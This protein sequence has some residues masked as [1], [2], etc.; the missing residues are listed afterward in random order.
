MELDPL[1]CNV[2][3]ARYEQFAAKKAARVRLAARNNFLLARLF[4]TAIIITTSAA[5]PGR[6]AI[7]P[8]PAGREE[9]AE[10]RRYDVVEPYL[11][12]CPG[13]APP[14]NLRGHRA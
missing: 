9:A 5:P 1:Y 13:R 3:V 12:G 6:D 8:S 2:I 11:P 4:S 14:A 7:P 10:D